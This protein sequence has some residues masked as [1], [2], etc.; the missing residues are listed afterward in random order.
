MRIDGQKSHLLWRADD[1]AGYDARRDVQTRRNTHAVGRL[2]TRLLEK[3]GLQ[4]KRMVTG[5]RAHTTWRR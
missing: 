4:P 1:Q 5:N 3:Q 2:L